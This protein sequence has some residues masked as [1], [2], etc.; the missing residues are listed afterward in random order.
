MGPIFVLTMTLQM[1][2]ELN[3]R[4]VLIDSIFIANVWNMF[5]RTPGLGYSM[6]VCNIMV[7]LY[8]N[9][10]IAW[11]IYYFFASMTSS[12]PWEFCGNSWNTDLCMHSSEAGNL[13]GVLRMYEQF[14]KVECMYTSI[15]PPPHRRRGATAVLVGPTA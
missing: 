12:L 4:L 15:V 10:I 9:V 6:V 1:R 8:Y 11:S 13:T 14:I 7:A 5:L 2:S 3:D